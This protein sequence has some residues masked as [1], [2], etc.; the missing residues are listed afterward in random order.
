MG[1]IV[2]GVDASG[3]AH[4][5]AEAASRLAASMGSRLH[6]VTAFDRSGPTQRVG[7]D[8]ADTVRAIDR[9]ETLV[10]TV[11]ADL[12]RA[13]PE[14]T[15]SVASGKPADV[16]CAEAERLGADVIVVG[17]KRT[18][19]ASRVLGAVAAKVVSHTPC[20][21]YIAHTS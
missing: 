16:I 17:N 18:Q 2:V 20:D 9:A 13:V 14:V 11:A 6:I 21:V 8:Q 5:A 1:I 7:G 10:A 4:D 19:G 12:R 15:T 3:T